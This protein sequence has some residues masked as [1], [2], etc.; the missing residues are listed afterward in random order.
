VLGME[1]VMLVLIKDSCFRLAIVDQEAGRVPPTSG[2]WLIF[3]FSRL[4]NWLHESGKGPGAEGMGCGQHRTKSSCVRGLQC[5]C[6]HVLI[7]KMI[8]ILR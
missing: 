5:N 7:V 4:V 2:T 8:A 6:V 3:N 1:P